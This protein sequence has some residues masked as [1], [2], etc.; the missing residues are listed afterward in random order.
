VIDDGRAAG[1]LAGVAGLRSACVPRGAG[2][3]ERLTVGLGMARGV[4]VAMFAPVGVAAAPGPGSGTLRGRAAL[5]AEPS[6]RVVVGGGAAAA[7]RGAGLDEMAPLV[8]RAATRTGLLLMAPRAVCETV[9][10]LD[11]AMDDGADLALLDFALRARANGIA[12]RVLADTLP[13]RTSSVDPVAPRRA[14]VD[15]NRYAK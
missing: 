13:V 8:E 15:A 3:V 5:L 7:I 11:P 6:D 1:F 4:H 10:A 14:F 12:V 2:D 9:G